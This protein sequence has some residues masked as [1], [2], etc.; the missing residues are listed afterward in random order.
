[1][2]PSEAEEA[3][4]YLE[5]L[6]GQPMLARFDQWPC[7]YEDNQ[8]PFGV[9]DCAMMVKHAVRPPGDCPLTGGKMWWRCWVGRGIG[10]GYGPTPT[11]AI[12][13]L[14]RRMDNAK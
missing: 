5:S 2:M 13:H 3:M 11:E 14:K 12:L 10:G 4:A 8:C 1:M 7:G 6:T 9:S